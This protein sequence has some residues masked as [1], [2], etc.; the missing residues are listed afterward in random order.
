EAVRR[1]DGHAV[2]AH[3]EKG[4][5]TGLADQARERFRQGFRN[6]Q[7]AQA[8]EVDRTARAIYEDLERNPVVLNSL[9]GGKF[10]IDVAAIAGTIAAGPTLWD[11]V[12]V[13]L[14][15]SL[16]HQLVELLGYQVVES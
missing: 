4:L 7:L 1:A 12:L 6:Y 9:R 5:D 8:D 14:V 11:F 16:T 10:A 13:P 2:W 3:V 15:T